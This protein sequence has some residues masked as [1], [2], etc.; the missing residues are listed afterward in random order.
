[1]GLG[2]GGTNNRDDVTFPALSA[3][4]IQRPR[5]VAGI[6]AVAFFMQM[7]DGTIIATSLTSMALDFGTDIVSLNIGFSAYLLAMAVF[8][9][10]AGWLSDQFGFR[11]V[12]FAAIALFTASSLACAMEEGLWSFAGAQIVQ[13]VGGAL[14]MPV[15]WQI[16]LRN[17][18]KFELVH[19]IAL[20]TWPAKFGAD[21]RPGARRLDH[22]ACP[23]AVTANF[24][25]PWVHSRE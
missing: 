2:D 9:P 13:G 3:Q 6:V 8:T 18:P 16:V 21:R 7:L 11:N 5:L 4:T 17:T 15:G 25:A 1:M 23:R 10:L 24:P 14:M 20:I 22:H 12:F 19:A